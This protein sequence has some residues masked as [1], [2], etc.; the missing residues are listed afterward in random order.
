MKY[1]FL[2]FMLCT[3][4]SFAQ[5]WK[6][7][8]FEVIGNHKLTK[9]ELLKYIPIK[10]GDLYK[11]DP[12]SWEKW[13]ADLKTHFK[14]HFT[15]C[16][17]VRYLDFKSFFTLEIVEPGYE[18]RTQF[19]VEPKEDI[20]LATLEIMDFY[21]RLYKRLWELF[22]QGIGVQEK[23]DKGYLDYADKEMH[24]IVE[25]LIRLTPKY[26]DNLLE[27]LEKDK[28]IN[29]REKAANL[30]NWTV[31][32]LAGSVVKANSLLDDPSELVRNNISRFT[33]HFIEK[34]QSQ[35]DR[36][37]LIDNLLIQLDRPSHGDRNKAIYNLVHLAEKFPADRP[38]M[39]AKGL[40]L[41]EYTANT[42]ILDNVS[43][44]ATQ[45][46]KLLNGDSK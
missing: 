12:I 27:V 24:E 46:I 2:I 6:W 1:L 28:D 17:S 36:Q 44:P 30:L 19:R 9:A 11:E 20:P 26:R 45:L 39:K 29:K 35:L 8:G 18:Y 31:T 7:A 43:G 4:V 40:P 15:K 3:E 13:C 23:T 41:I 37:G 5:D 10:V 34:V 22:N 42:S 21:E 16:S 32:N 25:K 14:F 33:F 38:Y